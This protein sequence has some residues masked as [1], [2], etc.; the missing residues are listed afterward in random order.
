MRKKALST[1][2]VVEKAVP[3]APAKRGPKPCVPVVFA[4][5]GGLEYDVTDI[6]EKAKADY[7]AGHKGGIHNCKV[8][9][10]ADEGMAYYVIN[11]VEGKISL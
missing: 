6:V 9:I 11:Q 5:A 4:Q 3:Q 1:E 8:Y 2:E 7:K 10:R